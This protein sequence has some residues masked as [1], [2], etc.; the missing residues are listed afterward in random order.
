[1][2]KAGRLGALIAQ[3]KLFIPL[4]RPVGAFPF[5]HD[6]RLRRKTRQNTVQTYYAYTVPEKH[7]HNPFMN[8]FH[9]RIYCVKVSCNME[10]DSV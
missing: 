9:L 3:Q 1:M 2:K 8:G 7:K 5:P 10:E 4:H 6:N